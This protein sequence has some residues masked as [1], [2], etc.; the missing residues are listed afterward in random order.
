MIAGCWPKCASL[1]LFGP[2]HLI[3]SCLCFEAEV[4]D[5]GRASDSSETWRA[6][7]RSIRVHAGLSHEIGG[8]SGERGPAAD[9]PRLPTSRRCSRFRSAADRTFASI[10]IRASRFAA[11]R[12]TATGRQPTGIR[13]NQTLTRIAARTLEHLSHA[14]SLPPPGLSPLR[15]GWPLRGPATPDRTNG[16]AQV[17]LTPQPNAVYHVQS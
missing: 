2:V 16:S 15:S 12:E 7:A 11:T 4:P 1:L 13:S 8:R 17:C 5:R 9:R 14:P 6:G 10:G 3:L